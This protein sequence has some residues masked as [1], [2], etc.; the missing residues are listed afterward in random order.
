MIIYFTPFAF[1]YFMYL[2]IE[3]NFFGHRLLGTRFWALAT[4]HW[5]LGTSFWAPASAHQLWCFRH[6]LRTRH[7]CI[8]RGVQHAWWCVAC[9]MCGVW[10]AAYVVCGMQHAW[11]MTCMACAWYVWCAACMVCVTCSMHCLC[12]VCVMCVACSMPGVCA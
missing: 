11:C 2:L 8:M 9:S 10:H 3:N 4:G 12:V 7:A 1:T 5:L 6:M